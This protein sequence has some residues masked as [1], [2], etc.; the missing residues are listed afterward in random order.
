MLRYGR[1]NVFMDFDSIPDFEHFEEFI[2]Q[3]V[4]E[5]DAMVS[6]IGPQWLELL[7]QKKR[8]RKPD[9]VLI[10][11]EEALANDKIVAPIRIQ[12][13]KLP[14][15]NHIPQNLR[16]IFE[17]NVGQLRDDQEILDKIHPLMDRLEDQLRRKGVVYQ[18][19]PADEQSRLLQKSAEQ[20]RAQ[21]NIHEAIGQFLLAEAEG[22]WPAALLWF[23]QIKKS[24][25]HVPSAIKLEEKHAEI[26]RKLK[27]EEEQRRLIEVAE[28]HYGFVRQ[29]MRLNLPPAQVAPV[30]Q[31]VWSIL[32]GYD[33]DNFGPRVKPKPRFEL[34]APF[35]WVD[36]PAGKVTIENGHGTFD[37]PAFKIAKYPVTNAQFAEFIKAGGYENQAWWPGVSW[38]VRQNEGWTEPRYWR[39]SK[40]NGAT[41]PVVG[42]S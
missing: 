32:E 3:K 33:P 36:I 5:C 23:E 21:F 11:L 41:H 25:H 34:P 14:D 26:Q 22:Q 24:G 15:E 2:R 10:E 16:P 27:A 30:L 39:D 35:A 20:P 29:M 1:E 9:Y 13:A 40:W 12:D 18:L 42:V 28:Y 7:Q 19:P 38:Q 37:V 31:E 17:R 4:R 8:D 6:I